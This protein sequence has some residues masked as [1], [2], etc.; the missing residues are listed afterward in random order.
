VELLRLRYEGISRRGRRIA[1][2]TGLSKGRER[3]WKE[4]F[5][6]GLSSSP[7]SPFFSTIQWSRV[8][9]WRGNGWA[10][11]DAHPAPS[12]CRGERGWKE[13]MR[14]KLGEA[15]GGKMREGVGGWKE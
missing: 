4:T 9:G 11:D 3:V 12:R 10:Q 13:E 14:G 15:M 6:S 8:V 7:F 5:L 2:D 1:R